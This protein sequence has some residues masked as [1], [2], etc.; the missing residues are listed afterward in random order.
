MLRV[1]GI[2]AVAMV[3]VRSS[4]GEGKP[5]PHTVSRP[6]KPEQTIPHLTALHFPQPVPEQR[7]RLISCP[8]TP[9]SLFPRSSSVYHPHTAEPNTSNSSTQP[10][11]TMPSKK[12]TNG[13]AGV[14]HPPPI[15]HADSNLRRNSSGRA[16]TTPNSSSSRKAATSS[17]T[18][19]TS[20]L[21]HSV[22][23]RSHSQP[24]LSTLSTLSTP[25]ITKH[26]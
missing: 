18:S 9:L 4:R 5:L 21:L 2:G 20:S 1:C 26:H 15:C 14:C 24:A 11:P 17:R 6:A 13:E 25:S 19:T 16:Q 7:A 3:M 23:R 12:D 8:H 10:I 22:V